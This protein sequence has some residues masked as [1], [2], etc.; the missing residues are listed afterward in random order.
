MKHMRVS[1]SGDVVP[2][3][4]FGF[5]YS[6]TGV[7]I[8]ALPNKKTLVGYVDVTRNFFSQIRLNSIE[9]HDLSNYYQ[10]IFTEK[11]SSST[12]VNEDMLSKSV[13]E[14]YKEVTG[15]TSPEVAT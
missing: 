7:N 8:C 14:L 2:V 9:K 4:P 10:N 11:S 6:Q 12:L 3:A 1:N 15:I 5:G 13:D